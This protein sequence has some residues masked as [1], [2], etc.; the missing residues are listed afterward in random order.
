[1]LRHLTNCRIIIITHLITALVSDA[2]ARL[3]LISASP[4][5]QLA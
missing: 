4:W 5:H 1:M 2:L 3:A